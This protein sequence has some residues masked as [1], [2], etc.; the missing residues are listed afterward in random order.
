MRQRRR[1]SEMNGP[2]SLLDQVSIRSRRCRTR[3]KTT[4]TSRASRRSNKWTLDCPRTAIKEPV[5]EARVR[6]TLSRDSAFLTRARRL[7]ASRSSLGL[8]R[9]TRR[10]A[11]PRS[12]CIPAL[13]KRTP[14]CTARTPSPRA[15]S[16]VVVAAIAFVLTGCAT[17]LM[18]TPVLY[19]GENAMPLFTELSIDSRRPSL[20]LLFITDRA[21]A[22]Q[23]DELAVHRGPIA[24]DGVRIG[25]GRVRRRHLLGRPRQ[26][27]HRDA[28]RQ[29]TAAQARADHGARSL[30]AHTV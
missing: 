13:S 22:E 16:A 20:D 21:P 7:A 30:S 5:L 14:R 25:D 26:G 18:P 19:T 3:P 27:K 8:A 2:R 15:R 29:S 12:I 28:T 11:D 6:L 24:F 17:T 10:T 23:A 9:S 1:D 4:S